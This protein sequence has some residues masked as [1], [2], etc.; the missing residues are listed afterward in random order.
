MLAL[1][2]RQPFVEQIF[3]RTKKIE[4]RSVP[5]KIKGR[6][7]I[8]ASLKPRLEKAFW[9]GMGKG[10]GDLAA[11]LIVGTVEIWDCRGKPGDYRWYLRKPK[12]LRTP[13]KPKRQPQPVW[14][15]P[16]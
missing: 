15:R 11:G 12:R 5:T 13:W 6:V 16:R 3:R 2:I 9:R 10:P 4:Y 7:L 14:F 1:S 8:Y